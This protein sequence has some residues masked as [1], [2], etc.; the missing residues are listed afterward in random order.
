MFRRTR[1]SCTTRLSRPRCASGSSIIATPHRRLWNTC[2]PAYTGLFTRMEDEYLRERL[3]DVRRCHHSPLRAISPPC[4]PRI[5]KG[6][7]ARSSW[8]PT[9]CCPR[10]SSALGKRE[11]AGIVTQSGGQTSHAAILARSRGVPAV[12]GVHGILRS[13]KNGDTVV[14]DGSSGM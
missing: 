11:V 1:R 14:V 10:R 3:V 8:W 13:V 2:W 4:W 5:P 6:S 12:S 9:S 7:T